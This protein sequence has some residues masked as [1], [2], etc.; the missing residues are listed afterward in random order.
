[1]KGP[2]QEKHCLIFFPFFRIHIIDI[3]EASFTLKGTFQSEHEEF[4]TAFVEPLNM[5]LF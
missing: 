2:C 1:M 4:R 3:D 5:R